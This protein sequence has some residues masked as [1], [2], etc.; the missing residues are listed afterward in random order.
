MP[1]NRTRLSDTHILGENTEST[2]VRAEGS[3]Q[4]GWLRRAPVCPLLAQFNII[5]AGIM[6]ARPPFEVVRT[7]QSGTFFLA[8]FEGS[9]SILVD[10][11]W[12]S[13]RAGEACLLPPHTVNALKVGRS[14]RWHFAWVRYLEPHG[15]IPVATATSPTRG[16]FDPSPL[17]HAIE[18]LHAETR[19]R[20][21]AAAI[22]HHW[23]ELIHSYV[24]R[25]ATPLHTDERVWKA[26]EKVA[27][28]LGA[29]WTL[30]SI[31]RLSNMSAE[32]FRRLCLKALSRSPGKH[33]IFLR[34]RF[35][36]EL[37]ATTDEKIETVARAVGYQNPFAFSNT[38]LKWIGVRPSDH[39]AEGRRNV[40]K[41]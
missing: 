17:L 22:R 34:M 27:A 31:A 40:E 13:I 14:P 19:G 9:G 5:H 41:G 36:A 18:G 1:V 39:R 20:I 3:D 12:K 37:L 29:D 7:D 26:W 33:L 30:D 2:V 8:C 24:R 35:A 15:T 25:F 6:R 38:F 23:V 28:N 16:G 4:R 10:G 32:H 11:G 21:E